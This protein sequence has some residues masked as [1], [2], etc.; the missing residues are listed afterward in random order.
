M[1]ILLGTLGV[2]QS[3]VYHVIN[4]NVD[5][6]ILTAR[7]SINASYYR[8][9]TAA[10]KTSYHCQFGLHAGSGVWVLSYGSFLGTTAY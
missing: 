4:F 9:S 3:F 6:H 10:C 1:F 2:K 7:V 8:Q 5:R